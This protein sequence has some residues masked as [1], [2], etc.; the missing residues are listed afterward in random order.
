MWQ[1]IIEI[2]LTLK[3][4]DSSFFT[5]IVTLAYIYY[6]RNEYKELKQELKHHVSE[7]KEKEEIEQPEIKG[8]PIRFY[9]QKAG[10]LIEEHRG[11]FFVM[12]RPN[13]EKMDKVFYN[14]KKA[15]EEINTMIPFFEE[16]I[17]RKR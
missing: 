17:K 13:G 15:E 5:G 6:M 14:L 16:T 2:I 7:A 1:I 12:I 10:Y 11:S 9:A 3:S 8:T 4:F